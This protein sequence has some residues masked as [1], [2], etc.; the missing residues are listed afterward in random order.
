M[1]VLNYF[2]SLDRINFIR[3]SGPEDFFREFTNYKFNLFTLFI[4]HRVNCSSLLL[5]QLLH[6]SQ[7]SNLCVQSIPSY[8][9]IFAVCSPSFLPDIGNQWFLSFYFVSIVRGLPILLIISKKFCFIDFLHC[10]CF[11]FHQC[12]L[13]SLLF[14]LS[15][16][17][18]FVLLYIFLGS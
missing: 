18:G 7:M 6:F 8:S 5:E 13:F 9:L 11:S 10:F 2:Q 17:V 15:A 4:L 12:L 14:I 16:E 1:F 3:L